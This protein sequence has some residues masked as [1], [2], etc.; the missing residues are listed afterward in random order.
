LSSNEKETETE[1][2]PTPTELLGKGEFV[3]TSD[4]VTADNLRSLPDNDLVSIYRLARMAL[5]LKYDRLT[6]MLKENDDVKDAYLVARSSVEQE[7]QKLQGLE[8]PKSAEVD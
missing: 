3:P 2:I 7:W 8:K 5:K 4:K 1:S 6:E